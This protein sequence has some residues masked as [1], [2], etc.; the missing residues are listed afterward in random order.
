V[1]GQTQD[2]GWQL[3]VRRTVSAPLDAVWNHLVDGDG[4]RDVLAAGGV[5]EE[6]R[7]RTEQRRIRVRWRE[8]GADHVTTLQLT[9]LP[10]AR[11]TTIAVHQEHL[12]GPDERARLLAVWTGRLESLVSDF[13]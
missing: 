5:V 9:V 7:S 3:G 13:D 11:G 12:S 2:A 1:T 10:A 4:L 6:I 8:D